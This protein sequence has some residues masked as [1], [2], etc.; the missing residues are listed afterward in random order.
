MRLALCLG[1]VHLCCLAAAAQTL[2]S[3]ARNGQLPPLIAK[4]VFEVDG[5]HSERQL[6]EAIVLREGRRLWPA[7]VTKSLRN[8]WLIGDFL[9]DIRISASGPQDAAIVLV[10]MQ[11][12]PFV[13]GLHLHGGYSW[14]PLPKARWLFPGRPSL[15]KSQLYRTLALQR[16]KRF[17]QAG[18]ER[19]VQNLRE[20]LRR[21]GFYQ[22]E[23]RAQV[24]TRGKA[25]RV[26]L[27][28][29]PGPPALLERI[30]FQVPPGHEERAAPVQEKLRS[31]IG[32][33]FQRR[34][35]VQQLEALRRRFALR[36][37]FRPS[38]TLVEVRAES[39]SRVTAVVGVDLGP[40]MDLQILRADSAPLPRSWSLAGLPLYESL[41]S[42]LFGN[43][44]AALLP[45]WDDR[46]IDLPTLQRGETNLRRWYRSRGYAQ[47]QVRATRTVRGKTNRAVVQY[48]INA[49]ARFT[50]RSLRIEGNQALS[51]KQIRRA[52]ET[53]TR[54]LFRSG[55]YDP[56]LFAEDLKRVRAVYRRQ[57]YHSAQ[58]RSAESLEG[59]RADL[60]ILIDEGPRS[61]VGSIQIEGNQILSTDE[62]L[63]RLPFRVGSP[64][65]PDRVEDGQ[66]ELF[67]LYN[68]RGFFATVVEIEEP[69]P[70]LRT[71]EDPP[72]PEKVTVR[73]Q[74]YEGELA[75][76]GPTIIRGLDRSARWVITKELTY[77][78]GEPFD[79]KKLYESASRVRRLG[80]FNVKHFNRIEEDSPLKTI[81]I[82]VEELPAGSFGLG[83]GF[84][85]RSQG[86]LLDVLPL[87]KAS[88]DVLYR[89]LGGFGAFIG[90]AAEVGFDRSEYRFKLGH[91]HLGAED[92]TLDLSLSADNEQKSVTAEGRTTSYSAR[93]LGGTLSVGRLFGRTSRASL[94]YRYSDRTLSELASGDFIQ[95]E[96]IGVEKISSLTPGFSVDSRD[97]PFN[98]SSGLLGQIAFEVAR[99]E[100][101]SQNDFVKL[102]L[103]AGT[104]RRLGKNQVL[105]ASLRLGLA[106]AL[107]F[108]ERFNIGGYGTLRGFRDRIGADTTALPPLPPGAEI[109]EGEVVVVGGNAQ[110]LYNL[111]YRFPVL[112]G[113]GGQAWADLG[114]VWAEAGGFKPWDVKSGLGLGLR[115][116]TP[117]GPLRFDIG[118]G[119]NEE[120]KRESWDYYLSIGH[121][122]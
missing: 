28:I 47:A 73:Y 95:T 114:N 13:S 119:F 121:P 89:N 110:V 66:Y 116:D 63:S 113:F 76:F 24:R 82:D 15:S 23:V 61:L 107:P 115:Y 6:R 108:G 83:F 38:L 42:R 118:W 104:Y 100:L 120:L 81:L 85:G 10:Q 71:A 112:F 97:N 37:H 3:A 122:F 102:I 57:G 111:E 52:L 59:G 106:D 51:T 64:F 101:G 27:H 105:A 46:S 7:D 80:L 32:L 40:T 69:R 34:A 55:R 1:A 48:E 68:D 54:G 103:Q 16:G 109:P 91:P 98:P 93:S 4:V 44:Y 36:G 49:G 5:P 33:R 35:F 62:L 65:V 53:R 50:V 14:L 92:L 22:A 45:I 17:E 79:L 75:V 19:S 72:W 39:A 43:V 26:D 18:L 30:E 87:N 74:L 84:S 20:L 12:R 70:L 29:K 8:L 90:L 86:A 11:R 117:I 21:D 67:S 41:W 77:R 88:G 25:V 31:Q 2:P 94:S 56:D 58:V 99:T 9:P 60:Q 96:D 78:R